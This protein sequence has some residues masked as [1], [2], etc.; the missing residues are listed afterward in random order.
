MKAVVVDAFGPPEQLSVREFPDPYCG[1]GQ[2]RV[3]VAAAG[4]NYPDTLVVSGKYQI[5]PPLPFVP[6]KD[7][8]GTVLEVGAGVTGFSPGDRVV[9]QLEYGGYAEQAAV[10]AENCFRLPDEISEVD[11]AA[12]G[13]AY[14]TA[15]FA[16]VDRGRFGPGETVL[17]HGAAGGVGGAAVQLVKA[18]GGVVLAGVNTPQ[19]AEVARRHGAD[20]V[21]DLAVPNLRDGLREQVHAVTGGAGVDVV[22]DTLGDEV[23]E[24]SLR[25]MAW[26]GRMVVI[27][28][29]AGRIPTVKANY[30]LV[31]NIEVSGLQWSDYRERMPERVA[32]V[33]QHLY[34]LYRRGAIRPD[35]AA[36]LPMGRVAEALSTL[37]AG[38]A[39]GKYVLSMAGSAG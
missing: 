27:G 3:R 7:V 18:L 25:A 31:K 9:G 16:L 33:Q 8:A 38:K 17:V 2:L 32:T 26:C 6:G 36:V 23:F 15:Y 28:F 5:L 24:A 29:A 1:E 22:L 11:A 4:I 30:L 13:L 12:M 39:S 19:Q 10:R 34:A 35:I 37:A 21:I 14:Q 20:H